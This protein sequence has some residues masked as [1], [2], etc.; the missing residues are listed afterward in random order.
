MVR[1]RQDDIQRNKASQRT[2]TAGKVGEETAREKTQGRREALGSEQERKGKAVMAKSKTRRC[3]E[4]AA[5]SHEQNAC[6]FRDIDGG[7]R[8]G[9]KVRPDD[10]PDDPY[11]NQRRYMSCFREKCKCPKCKEAQ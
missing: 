9:S 5:F 10:P 1:G 8:W 7:T 2:R 11:I 4:C 3:W 6:A